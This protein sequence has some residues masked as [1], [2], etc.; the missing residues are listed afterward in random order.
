MQIIHGCL[1]YY[2]YN[3]NVSALPIG[4]FLIML[5]VIGLGLWYLTPLSTIFQIYRCFI[6]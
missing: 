4:S 2:K 3:L 6:L 1:R 5:Y